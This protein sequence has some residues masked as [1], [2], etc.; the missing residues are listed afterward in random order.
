MNRLTFY[1]CMC[2]NKDITFDQNLTESPR[3]KFCDT[4]MCL[5]VCDD[6]FSLKSKEDFIYAINVL[7]AEFVYHVI[8]NAEDDA[9]NRLR[10]R[11]MLYDVLEEKGE[12]VNP[13]VV[14]T[15]F[16]KGVE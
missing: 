8:E 12:M 5:R 3:C 11:K 2:C 14:K 1:K 4:I 10:K 7:S 9:E 16:R 15:L 13:Y 6:Y